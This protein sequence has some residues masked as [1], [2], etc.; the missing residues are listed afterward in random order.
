MLNIVRI[1]ADHTLV[2]H[3][4]K[5]RHFTTGEIREFSMFPFLLQLIF[6]Q[7]LSNAIVCLM[8][9]QKLYTQVAQ[10]N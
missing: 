1:N 10:T 3:M 5:V 9:T 4:T 8:I 7:T 2:D 6:D